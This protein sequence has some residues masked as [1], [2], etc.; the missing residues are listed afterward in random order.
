MEKLKMKDRV[1][2]VSFQNNT[3]VIGLKYVQSFLRANG[4]DS[5]M[6]F[7]PHYDPSSIGAI[8]NFLKKV[9]PKILGISLMSEEFHNARAFSVAVKREIPEIH[10]VWGGIHPTIDPEDCLNYSDYVF[11]GESEKS[12]LEFVNAVFESKPVEGIMNLAYKSYGKII[13]NDLRHLQENLDE[14]AFPEHHPRGS[15]VLHKG[16]VA[17]LD[18]SLFKKY[19]RFSG[20]FLSIMTSRGC[21]FSCAYCCNSCFTK[22]Y[23]RSKVR[24]RSVNN[25]I[26]E[27]KQEVSLHPDIIYVKIHDDNFF[28]YDIAWI[29]EFARRY[30]REICKKFWCLSTPLHFSRDKV[31]VLKDAG[32]CFVHIGLQSGSE[33]VNKEVFNRFVP[34]DKFIEATEIANEYGLVGYYDVIL[35]NPWE[36]EDDLVEAIE[37]LLRI[38]KPYMLQLFSLSFYQGTE[39]F[40]RANDEGL[41]FEDSR[42]KNYLRFSPRFLNRLIRLVP[43]LPAFLIRFF[44]KNRHSILVKILAT[45]IYFPSIMFLETFLWFRLS[46]IS[47][48]YNIIKT[49]N[50]VLSF[51]YKGVKKTMFKKYV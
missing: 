38:P 40:R 20:K 43:L 46:M 48:D 27:L 50:M 26:D 5:R 28:S 4:V 17:R 15:F 47:F 25:V 16:K 2:L 6:L 32:F 19:A 23:G 41:L 44:L 37:T 1:L 42:S 9:G 35:D 8:V 30:K 10:I 24:K 3:D 18:A 21:P 12:F 22:L 39:I 49:M 7:V 13:I 36:E 45:S 34:N 29:N 31:A 14:L 51:F 33:R 11:V